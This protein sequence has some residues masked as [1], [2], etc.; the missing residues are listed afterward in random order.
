MVSQLPLYNERNVSR[1]SGWR[2]LLVRRRQSAYRY[3]QVFSW[4][5]GTKIPS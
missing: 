2:G 3:M 4:Y 1:R 5:S